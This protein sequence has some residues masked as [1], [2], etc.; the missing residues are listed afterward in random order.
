MERK[1]KLSRID[2]TGAFSLGDAGQRLI[3]ISVDFATN[4]LMDLFQKTRH[5][6]VGGQSEPGL[7]AFLPEAR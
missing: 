1:F 7:R 5:F 2:Q 3:V 6:V 4:F